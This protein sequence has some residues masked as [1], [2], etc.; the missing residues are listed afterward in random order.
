MFEIAPEEN[1]ILIV[2]SA[3]Q[4]KGQIGADVSALSQFSLPLSEWGLLSTAA[5]KIHLQIS[6]LLMVFYQVENAALEEG[7]VITEMGERMTLISPTNVALCSSAAVVEN[8]A[9]GM[10]QDS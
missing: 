4:W 6:Y 9:T 2:N 3:L 7:C 5:L 1:E 10:Q 8:V